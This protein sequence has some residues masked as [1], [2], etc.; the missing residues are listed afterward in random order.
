MALKRFVNAWTPMMATK[1]IHHLGDISADKPTLCVVYGE[2]GEN[3]IGEWAQG[4][5]FADV[6]FPKSTTR[7]LTEAETEKLKGTKIRVGG[8]T[9]HRF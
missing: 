7:P 9:H 2:D 8:V 4:F 1:A 5:G 3:F 6:K